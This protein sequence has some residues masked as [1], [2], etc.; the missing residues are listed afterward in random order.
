LADPVGAE[1]STYHLALLGVIFRFATSHDRCSV[2]KGLGAYRAA[3]HNAGLIE[4]WHA[5]AVD[6][7]EPVQ[8]MMPAYCAFAPRLS[9]S[10]GL[11]AL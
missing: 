6:T 9:A 8:C 3:L 5:I 4:S 10:H 1:R 2:L 11:M 7:K